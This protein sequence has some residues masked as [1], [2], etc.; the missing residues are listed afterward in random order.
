MFKPVADCVP[1]LTICAPANHSLIHGRSHSVL[2][3]LPGGVHRVTELA[4]VRLKL[5]A[6][7]CA[8]HAK[9]FCRFGLVLGWPLRIV[10]K[11]LL[12]FLDNFSHVFSE[13]GLIGLTEFPQMRICV[14]EW[15]L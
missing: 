13:H 4:V 5:E 1:E 8:F 7:G 11:L 3:C 9:G 14:L 15:F 12:P 6:L 10:R 2:E